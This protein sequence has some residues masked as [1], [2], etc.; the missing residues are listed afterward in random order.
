ME[1]HEKHCTMNPNRACRVCILLVEHIEQKPMSELLNILPDPTEYNE[2]AHIP[3]YDNKNFE[4]L[5]T[6]LINAMP[7]LREATNNCPACIMA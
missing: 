7:K 5:K 2:S 4:K 6:G 1:V 3:D